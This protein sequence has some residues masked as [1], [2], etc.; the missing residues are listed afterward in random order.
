MSACGSI[1]ENLGLYVQNTLKQYS[2]IHDSYLQD[3]PDFLRWLEDLNDENIVDDGDILVTVDVTGLYTNIDQLEGI[4]AV[5]EILEQNSDDDDRNIFILELLELVLSQNIFEFDQ[6]LYRQCIGAAMGGKPIP[7]Y[8]NI[9]MSK[10][11]K[12]IMQVTDGLFPDENKIKFFKRFLDDIFLIFKGNCKELHLWLDV[13]N[14]IHSSIKFTINHTS[15]TKCDNCDDDAKDKIP[16][17]D[18]QVEIK[19]NKI[20]TD[21]YK[22]PTDRNMYLL[23]SSCHVAS[24]SE[25]IP[26][27][28]CLRI[29]R[30]CSEPESR[31]QRLSE[32]K[33]MLLLRQYK[34][35]VINAAIERAKAVP[36]EKA[37]ERVVKPKTSDRPV[38]IVRYHPALPSVS[39]ITKKH[40]RTMC[41]DPEM[42]DKFPKPPLV[43]YKRPQT[44]R[45]KLIRAKVPSKNVKP[46][47]V[48]KG[49]F[50][51]KQI[52]KIC[53]YV[54]TCKKVQ[55]TNSNA[56]VHIQK[57]HDCQNSNIIYLIQCKKCRWAQYIGET[58]KSLETRF[59]EHLSDVR[60]N[61]DTATGKH[62]NL[63]GHSTSDMEV[64]VLEK[65][66]QEDAFYRKE[67]EHFHIQEWDV[68]RKGLNGKK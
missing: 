14:S 63:P 9:F 19:N 42:R 62:F 40:W 8:A 15:K 21:L 53:P 43:A 45:N 6:Q 31:D 34:V 4:K 41:L 55:A 23:P 26:Y 39:K 64:L 68:V 48:L 58:K 12:Q 49:M 65:I 47:R 18:T 30:I 13:I 57:H 33:E 25:N 22:K 10:L 36:R 44:I 38:F 2:N 50:K 1:T 3:T 46:K 11:D 52:C 16:F 27:S 5:R 7:D 17:L 59:S 29:I 56:V 60:R 37:L 66:H 35:G 54:K 61:Q 20:I 32:L 67:R 51:C 24:V 28:L